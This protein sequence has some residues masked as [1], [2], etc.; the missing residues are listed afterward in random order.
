MRIAAVPALET[1]VIRVADLVLSYVGSREM[2]PLI[3]LRTRLIH[4]TDSFALAMGNNNEVVSPI[5][6]SHSSHSWHVIPFKNFFGSLI[7]VGEVDAIW[8][9]KSSYY[10]ED[11]VDAIFFLPVY[12]TIGLWEMNIGVWR[13]GRIRFVWM[14]SL[15]TWRLINKSNKGSWSDFFLP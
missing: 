11:S 6:L 3:F 7:C 13:H 10:L 5:S 15:Y 9:E 8:T 2:L 4:K 12:L 14:A 1:Y